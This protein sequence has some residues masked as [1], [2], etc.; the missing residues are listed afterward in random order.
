MWISLKSRQPIPPQKKHSKK[1]FATKPLTTGMQN[2]PSTFRQ[3]PQQTRTKA[4]FLTVFCLRIS[5]ANSH[6]F[7][8][9]DKGKYVLL[10][11]ILG[12]KSYSPRTPIRF[13]LSPTSMW[14][15]IPLGNPT[16]TISCR[17]YC[18][19]V[20]HGLSIESTGCNLV[21]A[22]QQYHTKTTEKTQ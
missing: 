7:A 8:A 17:R 16:K 21:V 15:C 14:P 1:S 2:H 19:L 20:F 4:I 10:F 22:S 5:P 18:F 12:L 13:S 11:S 9:Q 6:A 3:P